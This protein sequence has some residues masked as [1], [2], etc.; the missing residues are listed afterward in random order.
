MDL[1]NQPDNNSVDLNIQNRK[2]NQ[3]FSSVDK[4]FLVIPQNSTT[5]N[6][7]KMKGY[8]NANY[9]FAKKKFSTLEDTISDQL[10]DTEVNSAIDLY[11]KFFLGNPDV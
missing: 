5:L 2:Y 4:S 7:L 8:D 6:K 9:V 3:S 1:Q 11:K 10:F